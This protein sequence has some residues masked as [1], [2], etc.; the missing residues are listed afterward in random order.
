M[1]GMLLDFLIGENLY[2]GDF[3]R[4]APKGVTI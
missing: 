3:R 2:V 4:E 1:M